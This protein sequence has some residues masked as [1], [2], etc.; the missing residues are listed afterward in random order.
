[1]RIE[2]LAYKM[3]RARIVLVL[4]VLAVAIASAD[5]KSSFDEPP[6]CSAE[7]PT[8]DD[9]DDGD[10]P[11]TDGAAC[12]EA[13]SAE[14]TEGDPLP[15]SLDEGDDDV[16]DTSTSGTP[17]IHCIYDV[18]EIAPV[19]RLLIFLVRIYEREESLFV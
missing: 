2:K 1:M 6:V 3:L 8:S 10:G 4:L 15:L 17:T 16:D 7:T 9:D 19:T 14:S 13:P 11:S 18:A 5:E 12:V